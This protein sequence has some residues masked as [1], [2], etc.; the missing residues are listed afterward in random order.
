V[1]L[2]FVVFL[3]ATAAF[4][5]A[6]L[7]PAARSHGGQA[8][9]NGPRARCRGI[10]ELRVRAPEH[11]YELPFRLGPIPGIRRTTVR[12]LQISAPARG[13]SLGIL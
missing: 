8:A 5:Y 9:P 6:L 3:L 11:R 7:P 10:R 2:T 1:T 13:R 12:S 4:V